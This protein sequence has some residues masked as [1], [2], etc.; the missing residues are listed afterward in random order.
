MQSAGRRGSRARRGA[1]AP[2]GLCVQAGFQAT[3][4]GA[5]WPDPAERR[6]TAQRQPAEA[7]AW[8][9]GAFGSTASPCHT[10]VAGPRRG[11]CTQQ[12]GFPS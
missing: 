11:S 10:H 7:S 6:M 2:A 5:A 1:P 3:P 12:P 8:N 9:A 4:A